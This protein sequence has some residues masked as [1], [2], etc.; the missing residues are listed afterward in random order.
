MLS[1][2]NTVFKVGTYFGKYIYLPFYYFVFLTIINFLYYDGGDTPIVNATLFQ[3]FLL[4]IF[5]LAHANKD[6][7]AMPIC[8]YGIAFG[9]IF[10]SILAIMGVGVEINPENMRL[11]LFEMN[12]NSTGIMMCI[13]FIIILSEFVMRD[14]LHLGIWRFCFLFTAIPISATIILTASRTAV[15]LFVAAVIVVLFFNPVKN[16]IVKSTIFVIGAFALLLSAQ[17]LMTDDNIMAA[18]LEKSVES[19]D[20]SGRD[21]LWKD[22]TSAIME[23]P[24]WGYGETGYYGYV[25][26]KVIGEDISPHNVFIEVMALSG[27][28][29]LSMWMIFWFRITWSAWYCYRKAKSLLP[30]L[31]LLPIMVCLFSGQF[32]TVSWAYILYAYLI[33]ENEKVK[34]TLKNIKYEI[35]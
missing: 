12:P 15:V 16:K 21:V 26:K 32:I 7:N 5:L 25:T 28:I 11:E 29:G 30:M 35:S 13:G 2:L 20:L 33:S 19:G 3:C 24:I 22:V 31:M 27:M 1:L 23:S 18:R 17:K 8:L 10:Q 34:S 9:C 6:A 4:F 14:C